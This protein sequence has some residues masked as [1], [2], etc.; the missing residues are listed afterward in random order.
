MKLEHHAKQLPPAGDDSAATSPDSEAHS[1]AEV[2]S[3]H[4]KPQDDTVWD[5]WKSVRDLG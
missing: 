3:M 1:S 4:Q 5:N 2:G